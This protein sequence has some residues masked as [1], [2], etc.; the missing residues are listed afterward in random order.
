MP[1]ELLSPHE[2]HV[3]CAP[4]GTQFTRWLCA[5]C[6]LQEEGRA[7]SPTLGTGYSAAH[8]ASMHYKPV[9]GVSRS[10][11]TED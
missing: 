1:K 7:L 9:N 10:K 4:L 8:E 2:R 11:A 6:L 5:E 3:S